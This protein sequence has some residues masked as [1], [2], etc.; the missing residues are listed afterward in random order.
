[1]FD[2]LDEQIKHDRQETTT[3]KERVFF[4]VTA[5]LVAVLAFGGVY[6]GVRVLE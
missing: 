6:F 4:W 2:S 3:P 1:M 5:A